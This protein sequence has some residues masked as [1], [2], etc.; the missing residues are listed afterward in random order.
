MTCVAADLAK[1][2]S[3]ADVILLQELGPWDNP[4]TEDDWKAFKHSIFGNR[5]SQW[6]ARKRGPY[7]VLARNQ[8]P[9]PPQYHLCCYC[10]S[11]HCRCREEFAFMRAGY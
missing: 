7:A 6:T 2:L 10:C 9:T 8:D 5:A 4:M 1:A 3:L 11:C